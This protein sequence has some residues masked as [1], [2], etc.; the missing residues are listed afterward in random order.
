MP[1]K[2]LTVEAMQLYSAKFAAELDDQLPKIK[3]SDNRIVQEMLIF[4]KAY[5]LSTFVR[6]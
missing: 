6:K 2:A 1:R 5:S 4:I 3:D